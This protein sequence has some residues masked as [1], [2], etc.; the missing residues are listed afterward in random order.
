MKDGGQ[1]SWPRGSRAKTP[2][3]GGVRG[4]SQKSPNFAHGG[5]N[6]GG[7][8]FGGGPEQGIIKHEGFMNRLNI[9]FNLIVED[10][11]H[12]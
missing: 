11:H 4:G 7:G 8:V 2:K 9:R 5:G 1:G 6:L 10:D 3:K 12:R